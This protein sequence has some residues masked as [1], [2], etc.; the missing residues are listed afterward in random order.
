VF[1]TE[2]LSRSNPSQPRAIARRDTVSATI[3]RKI[4]GI[5]SPFGK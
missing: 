5:S 2:A 1:E 3:G 4:C